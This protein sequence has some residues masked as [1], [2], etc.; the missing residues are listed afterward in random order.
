[1]QMILILWLTSV[2][3]IVWGLV[4][5]LMTMG[6][7]LDVQNR[8]RGEKASSSTQVTPFEAAPLR[9]DTTWH[10]QSRLSLLWIRHYFDAINKG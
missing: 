5:W 7:P 9:L 6:Q 1:M 3:L 10:E 2:F 8:V 4:V